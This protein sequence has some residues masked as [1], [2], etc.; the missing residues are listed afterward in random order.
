MF[1]A[2]RN[3]PDAW[4]EEISLSAGWVSDV[5]L[6]KNLLH[7]SAGSG[8]SVQWRSSNGEEST[9]ARLPRFSSGIEA[10]DCPETMMEAIQVEL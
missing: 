3:S 2:R 4:S 10:V 7:V 9:V 1:A 8:P 5:D 6:Y